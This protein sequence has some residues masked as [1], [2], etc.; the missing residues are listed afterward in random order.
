MMN[1]YL[2]IA[3]LVAVLAAGAGGFKLGADHEIAANARE[4]DHIAEAVDAANAASA[5]AIADLKIVNKTIQNEVRR[6]VETNT[7]YRDCVVPANGVQLANQALAGS[8]PADSGK[9]PK[10]DAPSK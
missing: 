9:L 6:E 4:Q 1:P 3:A 8:K 10:A 2:I 7:I 5:K